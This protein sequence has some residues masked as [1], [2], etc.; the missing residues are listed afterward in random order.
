MTQQLKLVPTWVLLLL[1]PHPDS[2]GSDPTPTHLRS[3]RPGIFHLLSSH[4]PKRRSSTKSITFFG[5]WKHVQT[6]QVFF[7]FRLWDVSAVFVSSLPHYLRLLLFQLQL[8]PRRLKQER[9][10]LAWWKQFTG[11]PSD[12][13]KIDE[14]PS[15]FWDLQID[16]SSLW[17]GEAIR[18]TCIASSNKCLT[19]VVTRSY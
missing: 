15:H 5:W 4:N 12:M 19:N 14:P 10:E 18:N 6:L 2:T 8:T 9:K 1:L 11:I 13:W 17:V 7:H 16:V 3:L